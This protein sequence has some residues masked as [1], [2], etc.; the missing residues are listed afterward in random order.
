M[1][2]M[3]NNNN[4]T[5][6]KFSPFKYKSIEDLKEEFQKLGL[7]IPIR[8]ETDI[9]KESI[10]SEHLS[11]ANRLTIQPMEGFDASLDGS[12]G[13][14]TFRRYK[15]YAEGGTGLIWFEATAITENA[16]SNPH[17]LAINED[18]LEGFEHLVSEV[19]EI[20]TNTLD[21]LGLEDKILCILQLNHS[22]RYSKSNSQKF[23]IRAYEDENLDSAIHVK[24]SQGKIISDEELEHLESKW[25]EKAL[26]A[27]KAG[28]DGVDI[29]ACHGYLISEL[30]TARKRKNSRYGG[31]SLKNRA[32]FYLNIIEKLKQMMKNED[33]IITTRL[34]IYNGREYPCSFG[35]DRESQIYPPR[36]DLT[37]P[38]ELLKKLYDLGVKLVNITMGNPHYKPFITRPYDIPTKKGDFPPEHPLKSI[39]RLVNLTSRIKKKLPK[40]MT[41]IGSGYSYLRQF[42]G[43]IASGLIKEKKVDLCGFGRMAFANPSFPKQIFLDGEIDKNKVC[44]TCSKCSGLM[45]EGKST[46]CV[47]RD[48]FYRKRNK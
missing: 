22:G 32:R 45:R 8:L 21:S 27:K 9:L 15:R 46:G 43:Y 25:I 17:Q 24:P 10:I 47:V 16:K 4:S 14:L 38:L 35:V 12:P 29:K 44:I 48:P 23:P 5:D 1:V 28:F 39:Y 41:I 42:G 34:G 13:D 3:I 37:E 40:D 19:K 2:Y 6:T 36:E 18:N 20:G 33:F 7:K 31:E 11:V 26:L 30:L